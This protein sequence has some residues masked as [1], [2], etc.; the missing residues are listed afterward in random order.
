MLEMPFRR[1]A[2]YFFP[3]LFSIVFIVIIVILVFLS[4]N[5]ILMPTFYVD[6]KNYR[7]R[8]DNGVEDYTKN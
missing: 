8:E 7:P 4:N 1:K 6:S 2:I 3:L 5:R